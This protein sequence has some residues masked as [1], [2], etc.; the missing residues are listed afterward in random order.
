MVTQLHQRHHLEPLASPSH[1]Q[2]DR[3]LQ[4]V[5]ATSPKLKPEPLNK[6]GIVARKLLFTLLLYFLYIVF[7]SSMH[8]NL[9][10]YVRTE[11][12]PL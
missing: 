1:H 6:L 7:Y 2:L 9:L 10:L 4:P 8:L 11:K 3:S 5:S 12:L